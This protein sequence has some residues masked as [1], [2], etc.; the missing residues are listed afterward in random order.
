MIE[1][2][3]EL[4]ESNIFGYLGNIS[5]P[6]SFLYFEAFF[7]ED[8]LSKLKEWLKSKKIIDFSVLRNIYVDETNRGT[9][10]GSELVNLFCQKSQNLP[11]LL[12]ASPDEDDF[13]LVSWYEKKGFISTQ[14][15]CED[16]PLMIKL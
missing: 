4:K 16:G 6:D 10:I 7:N 15:S 12:L 3:I 5:D 2:D 13:D 14:F 8:D 11:I 1:I 9:G